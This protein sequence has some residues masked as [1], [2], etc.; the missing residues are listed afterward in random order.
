MASRST[1]IT[2][3]VIVE[4]IARADAAAAWNLM[5]GATYGLWA[6]F[7]PQN[8]VREIYGTPDAVVAGALW[9]TRPRPVDGAFNEFSCRALLGLHLDAP[10]TGCSLSRR[11]RPRVF[12]AQTVLLS[13]SIG[14][15]L[16]IGGPRFTDSGCHPRSLA[17]SRRRYCFGRKQPISI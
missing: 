8:A 7:L 11:Q 6:A 4:E 1:P 17:E 12:R 10:C 16:V 2:P 13:R 15:A 9:P 3:M 5:L 14:K